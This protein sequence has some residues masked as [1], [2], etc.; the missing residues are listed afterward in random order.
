M[1]GSVHTSQRRCASSTHGVVEGYVCACGCVIG[2]CE[3]KNKN[4]IKRIQDRTTALLCCVKRRRTK[5]K[6]K[7]NCQ[8]NTF[9]LYYNI[10][11]L[12]QTLTQIGLYTYRI[13]INGR[14]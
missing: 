3:L 8:N 13:V 9:I 11:C 4:K 10:F 14:T 5:Q 2:R 7:K 1:R 12:L 6:K